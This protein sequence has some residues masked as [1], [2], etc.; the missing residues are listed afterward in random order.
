MST[1]RVRSCGDDL[2]CVDVANPATAQALAKNLRSS[3][4]WLDVVAGISSVVL[5][6]DAMTQDV[7]VA[8]R[9]ASDSLDFRAPVDNAA[10]DVVEISISYGGEYGPDLETVCKRLGLSIDNFVA[11][12][13]AGNY[14]VDMLGFTPGFA[15]VSGVDERLD[16]PRLSKPR[17]HV[18][19]G[20]VGI[21]SGHTG[22]YALPGPGGWAIIGRTRYPLFD[23]TNDQPFALQPG[24]RLRFVADSPK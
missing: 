5:R 3:G 6:F 8:L 22:L 10:G 18:P 11:L 13:T 21:A 24:M 7:A 4:E 19:A 17:A 1:D 12:H 16:V 9:K 2:I 15:Y 23:S 20:S 14:V